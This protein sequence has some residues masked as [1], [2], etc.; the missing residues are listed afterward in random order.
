MEKAIKGI[1]L[2]VLFVISIMIGYLYATSHNW[3]ASVEAAKNSRMIQVEWT[4]DYTIYA[5]S[6]TKVLY[7]VYKKKS[8]GG[9]FSNSSICALVMVDQ[10]GKPLLYEGE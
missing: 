10:D 6:S 4:E 8:G 1:V 3:G 5:D 7:I 9:S 2:V